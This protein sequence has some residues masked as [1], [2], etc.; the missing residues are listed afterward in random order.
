MMSRDQK[1][2]ISVPTRLY[3]TPKAAHMSIT[4]D[5]EGVIRPKVTSQGFGRHKYLC[6]FMHLRRLVMWLAVT[7]HDQKRSPVTWKWHQARIDFTV[8]GKVCIMG[9]FQL[10][11]SFNSQ[12]W[13]N[14]WSE[15]MSRDPEGVIRAEVMSEG[16]NAF[17]VHFSSYRAVTQWM[18][19]IHDRKWC[20]VARR[21][22]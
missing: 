13:P 7:S 9:D 16:I 18:C 20:H 5:P 8:L 12:R 4:C 6:F 22:W 2:C 10:L 11:Q 3:L 21:Y 15:V 1:W 14:T 19:Q 17:W